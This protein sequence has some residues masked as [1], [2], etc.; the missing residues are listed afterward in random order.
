VI[1]FLDFDGVL[2]P[3]AVYRPRNKPLELRAE[4]ELFM[5]AHL[6]EEVL[7][8]HPHVEIVLSTS[9]VRF[10]GFNKTMKKMP[11]GLRSR[12][13]G[14]TWHKEMRRY[15]GG[16]DPFDYMNR[17]QQIMQHV[18]KNAVRNWVALD[19][20]HSG[21]EVWPEQDLDNLVLCTQETGI[22]DPNILG[23]LRHKLKHFS[24]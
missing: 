7:D 2:H 9:W 23:E 10:L 21:E 6:L 12:V 11:E 13:T 20:L 14:A 17:H 5:H 18:R 3:D 1:L 8:K 16:H 4:G 24:T 19:D 15:G 22:S